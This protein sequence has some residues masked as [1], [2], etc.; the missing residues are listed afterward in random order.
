MMKSLML[1]AAAAMAFTSCS[2]DDAEIANPIRPEGSTPTYNVIIKANVDQ[3]TR[4]TFEGE[5][6]PLTWVEGD[7]IAVFHPNPN[8]QNEWDP[9]EELVAFIGKKGASGFEFT[10]EEPKLADN[11]LLKGLY[12]NPGYYWGD[13]QVQISENQSTEAA[14]FNGKFAPMV[15]VPTTFK[16]DPTSTTQV[17]NMQFRPVTSIIKV[18]V[19]SDD[20]TIQ[21]DKVVSIAMEANDPISGNVV[22]DMANVPAVGEGFT[23]LPEGNNS[24]TA[25]FPAT[26]ITAQGADWASTKTAEG[27]LCIYPGI[28]SGKFVVTTEKGNMYSI[29]FA[30]KEFKRGHIYRQGLKLSSDN[31]FKGA[32]IQSFEALAGMIDGS[33]KSSKVHFIVKGTDINRLD[34][35][36]A[37]KADWEANYPGE[38][39]ETFQANANDF[40]NKNGAW[41]LSSAEQ[42]T[43]NTTGQTKFDMNQWMSALNAETTYYVIYRAFNNKKGFTQFFKAEVT[44]EKAAQTQVF[45]LMKD[46]S[47]L[48]DGAQLII[49]VEGAKNYLPAKAS[50]KQEKFMGA[51]YNGQF[52]SKEQDIDLSL[53]P[54]MTDAVWVCKQST[55]G[56]TTKLVSAANPTGV[57]LYLKNGADFGTTFSSWA[58]GLAFEGNAGSFWIKND[59]EET[60]LYYDL[61]TFEG[62]N[63]G[64]KSVFNIYIS[65]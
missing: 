32:Q 6:M 34:Y 10:S 33:N 11:E 38:T 17:V 55:S 19:V 20:P 63:D 59:S 41:S 43:L 22:V 25:T 3:E 24:V 29:N 45:K 30:A 46:P 65:K 12:P 9:K 62:R 48:T 16:A 7:N 28:H 23:T 31:E 37:S 13:I 26:A 61:G 4:T 18:K 39:A 44:T 42:D 47:E 51:G 5:N 52:G 64:K 27:Y 40:I 14:G 60:Y 53:Y 15:G 1:F 8:I 2:K 57:G 54:E 49:R 21:N 56:A 58:T 35:N 50:A 36:I